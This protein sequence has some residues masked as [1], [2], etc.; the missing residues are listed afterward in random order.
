MSGMIAVSREESW[1]FAG[2]VF[3]NVLERTAA[4]LGDRDP[5]L[6]A[7]MEEACEHNLGF[8]SLEELDAARLRRFCAAVAIVREKAQQAGPASFHMPDF[9]P[10]FMRALDALISMLRA[11]PRLNVNPTE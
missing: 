11:D 10:G 3:R 1:S 5:A 7:E 4:E 6:T 8:L 9:H 2:W